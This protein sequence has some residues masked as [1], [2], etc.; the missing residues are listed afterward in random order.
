VTTLELAE[1]IVNT[2]L[3]SIPQD[4]ISEAKRS[5]LNFLGVAIAASG[6]PTVDM[7][8]AVTGRWWRNPEATVLG[9]GIKVDGFTASLVNGISS[10][11]FD[12]DDTLL[13]TILHPSAPIFPALLAHAE[14]RGTRPRDLLAAFVIGVEASQRIAQVVCPSHYDRGWH[15]TGSVG[16]FGAA[17]AVGR[18]VGLDAKRMAYALGLSAT[19]PVGLREMFGTHT[20]PFHPG[21]AAANGLLAALLAEQGF[22]SSLQSIEAP[23]GFARVT[24]EKQDFTRLIEGWG[25]SWEIMNN[26]YKPFPCGVV[27]HPAI[28]AVI[29]LRSRYGVQARDVLQLD[30]DVHPLVLEL[31]GKATPKDGLEAKFSVFHCAAAGLIDGWVGLA[32]FKDER[33]TAPDV[34][35][36]RAKVSCHVD[37]SLHEDQTRARAALKDG[38]KPEVFVEHCLGSKGNPMTDELLE[39]KFLDVTREVLP[40]A[41]QRELLSALAG[42]DTAASLGTLLAL[43]CSGPAARG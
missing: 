41:R 4:A 16:A 23:R 12:Y 30:L 26:S 22:T 40:E 38:R 2:P 13:D 6:H 5:L 10:H 31:C 11:I 9:R 29:G 32:Q 7:V 28:D 27:I 20:K 39:R 37:R 8:L 15:V 19:Q 3:E 42:L 33:V 34:L 17:A 24:S 18:L 36:L 35:E 25:A 21:K 43:T 14:P 1:K